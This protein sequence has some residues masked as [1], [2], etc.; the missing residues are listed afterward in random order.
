MLSSHIQK[1][2]QVELVPIQAIAQSFDS[3][4]KKSEK[5]AEAALYLRPHFNEETN[6]SFLLEYPDVAVVYV[7]SENGFFRFNRTTN[8]C[9]KIATKNFVEKSA[10]LQ[11][12][13]NSR[14]LFDGQCGPLNKKE[15]RCIEECTEISFQL[16]GLVETELCE[17]PYEAV[18]RI[19][20]KLICRNTLVLDL[21]IISL[22]ASSSQFILAL[23]APPIG[24]LDLSHLIY[25]PHLTYDQRVN[26]K[27]MVDMDNVHRNTI[28][29]ELM[30]SKT[31]G[32]TPL[33]IARN[34]EQYCEKCF[35]DSVLAEKWKEFADRLV[36]R[37]S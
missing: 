13:I 4:S 22:N 1:D 14:H 17:A 36:L 31:A 37:H 15:V 8:V 3:L 12:M 29:V 16:R 32:K 28:F 27:G 23:L 33:E 2:R 34:F 20:Q 18:Y 35:N 5:I 30:R 11:S 6:R 19:A 21:E 24:R 7:V 26:L 25:W 9:N 10:D